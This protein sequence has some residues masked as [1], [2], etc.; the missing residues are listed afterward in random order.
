M[1]GLD[2]VGGALLCALIALTG[3]LMVAGSGGPDLR[4]RTFRAGYEDVPPSEFRA[5]DGSPKGAVIDVM[6]Q[7]AKRRGIKLQWV[8]SEVGS[9]RSLSSGETE[10]W[11][12][13][14]DLPWRRANFFVSRPYAL[15]RY[16]LVVDQ[17]SPVTDASQVKGQIIAVK[18][19]PG[20]METAAKWFLPEARIVRQ[21][22]DSGIFYA[23]CTGEAGGGLVAERVEQHIG[24]VQTGPCAGHTFRYL[25]IPN[26][27][28]NAGIAALRG[29]SDAIWAAKAL[30]EEIS[31]MASDGTMAGIYFSWYR[32]SNNDAATIDLR[33]EAKQRNAALS[34]ALGALV[35]ILGVIYWQYRRSRLAWKV[36]DEACVRAT[37]ATMAKSEFLANMS[38]EIRTPMNAIIGMTSLLL[39]RDLDVES[40]DYVETIRN[41][42]DSLLTI[43][44]DILDFS[45]IESGKLELEDQPFDLVK[46]A[47][48]AVDLLSRRAAEKGLELV[49]DIHPSVPRWIFGDV[50]RLRQI[51]VNLVS[52]GVKFTSAGEVVLTVQSSADD[53]GN[54]CTHFAVRDTGCGIPADR[55]D[56]LFRSFSQVDA[57]T[58]RN[59]GGTGLGLAISKR[60][61]ELM[62]GR[63]WVESEVGAGSVFQFT[64]VQK[65]APQEVA[66]VVGANW[67]G[68]KILIVDDNAT[69]RRILVTQLLIWELQRGFGRDAA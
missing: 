6:E 24:E 66:P 27:Y 35:L 68:K 44:N 25:P 61:T 62:G 30:R 16:W 39:D 20:M 58:T 59:Y 32:E 15:V 34:V 26:G 51:L 55:L 56:R 38:H 33:E 47:E 69:N 60:L 12:I 65:L 2:R 50:T 57:S 64:I 10:V 31:R 21:Q 14:S 11:P 28:G 37:D 29:N 13:F 46:C 41:S 52:N 7:A 9:E 54:A 17:N 40:V 45:K 1:R 36:A 49:V 48:D 67:S 8:H 22:E 4:T 43:I 42:S 23:I 53:E 3:V 18:Y 63:I 19:P 5:Q